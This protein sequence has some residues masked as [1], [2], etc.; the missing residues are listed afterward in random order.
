MANINTNT[1]NISID[2]KGDEYVTL[3][4][5]T[6]QLL[7][8]GQYCYD[9]MDKCYRNKLK[10]DNTMSHFWETIVPIKVYKKTEILCDDAD[11]ALENI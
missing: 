1:I 2:A 9:N 4:G 7:Y 6:E 11:T 10:I 5:Y 8:T 3:P